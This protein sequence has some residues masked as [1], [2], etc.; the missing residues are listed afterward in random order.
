MVRKLAW[1]GVAS[2]RSITH[3]ILSLLKLKRHFFHIYRAILESFFYAYSAIIDSS[4]LL[5]KHYIPQYYHWLTCYI[6]TRLCQCL[7]KVVASFGVINRVPATTLAH[8]VFLYSAVAYIL[9][10]SV[11]L[12]FRPKSGFKNKL[13]SSFKMR[14]FYNSGWVC[15]QGP[16]RGDGKDTFSTHHQWK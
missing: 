7:F 15:R 4:F 9:L 14:P 13:S 10:H 3:E 12:A 2:K 6:C 16:T 1:H 5:E 8:N 11:N